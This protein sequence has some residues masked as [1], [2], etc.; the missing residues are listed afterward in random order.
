M[1]GSPPELVEQLVV[2]ISVSSLER[3][4]ALYTALGFAQERRDGGFAVLRWGDRRLFLDETAN[5]IPL[6]GHTR[7]NVRIITDDVD[8][9]WALA[10]SLGMVVEQPIGDRRYGIR[11]FTVL[12]L[13]GFGL[14]FASIL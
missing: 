7:A 10:H 5:L 6:T 12:D 11:D 3:S 1:I 8:R 2:E 4:L 9:M 14:R 13:D